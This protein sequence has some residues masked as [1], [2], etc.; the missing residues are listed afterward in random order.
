M[1]YWILFPF[2]LQLL[3]G[4]SLKNN[5]DGYIVG[6]LVFHFFPRIGI[7]NHILKFCNSFLV[8]NSE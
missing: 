4:K 2:C 6:R 8:F 1:K 3:N 5:E 7:I